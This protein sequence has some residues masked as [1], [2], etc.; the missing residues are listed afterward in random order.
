MV[1]RK[2]GKANL[3][4]FLKIDTENSKETAEKPV[5][6]NQGKLSSLNTSDNI[7]DDVT[8]DVTT[9]ITSDATCD[10]TGDTTEDVTADITRDITA[11]V[12]ED[13]THYVNKLV[14]EY[15][16]IITEEKL[17]NA[18]LPQLMRTKYTDTHERKTWYFKKE[19]IKRIE[20]FQKTTGLD[21]SSIVNMALDI[22]FRL[23][24]EKKPLFTKQNKD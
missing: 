7:T 2:R 5:S 11:D 16:T 19:N 20:K 24:D 23:V 13:V 9:D 14:T 8:I 4:D 10:I 22:F 3:A 15:V 1:A 18:V 21:A 12:T 17:R 6:T